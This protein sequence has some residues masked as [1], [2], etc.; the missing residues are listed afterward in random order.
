[1]TC[2]SCR[3][4]APENLGSGR[5]HRFPPTVIQIGEP[6]RRRACFPLVG[7]G[8]WCGEHREKNTETKSD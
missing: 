4:F 8:D 7:E 1:M 3:Y 5:C 6:H 2:L